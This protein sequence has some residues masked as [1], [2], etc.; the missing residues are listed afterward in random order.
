MP[1]SGGTHTRCYNVDRAAVAA[2]VDQALEGLKW[3]I[4]SRGDGHIEATTGLS[5]FSTGTSLVVDVEE[6]AAP[7]Q[8]VVTIAARPKMK[9]LLIDYGQSTR[10]AKRIFRAVEEILGLGPAED[11][12]GAEAAGEG[13]EGLTCASCGAAL[14]AGSKFC[15]QCGAK[16]AASD[17]PGRG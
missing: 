12:S 4:V 11:E 13:G 14:E 2:A 9:T 16:I 8:T 5:P 3:R 6:G 15:Q 10:D 17:V 1:L 7:G